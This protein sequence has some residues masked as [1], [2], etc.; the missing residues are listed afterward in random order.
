MLLPSD[1]TRQNEIA[2]QIALLS[3]SQ[4]LSLEAVLG[5]GSVRKYRIIKISS[6][7]PTDKPSSFSDYP[8]VGNLKNALQPHGY[9]LIV[10]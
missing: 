2:Y 3:E 5:D 6:Q 8:L 10:Q 4:K 1:L 7:L 9:T